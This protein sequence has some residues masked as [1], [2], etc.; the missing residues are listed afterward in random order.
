[1]IRMTG[2]ISGLDTDTIVAGLMSAQSMKKTKLENKITKN[3][4]TTE[5]WKTLNSK[6]YSLYT[7]TLS[8]A[9]TQGSYYSKSVSSSDSTKVTVTGTSSAIDGSHSLE[10]NKLAS[11]QYVTGAKIADLTTSTDEDGNVTE[12]TNPVTGTTLLTSL[13][14]NVS[15]SAA[16]SINITVGDGDTSSYKITSTSTVSD[17]VSAMKSAGISANYDTTQKR[18]FLSA[19]ESGKDSAFSVNATSSG[20]LSETGDLSLLGLANVSYSENTD[21]SLSY[22]TST[23]NDNTSV[24]SGMSLVGASDSEIVYN[25]ATL[26]GNTNS[27]TANGLTFNLLGTTDKA[28]TLSVTNDSSSVYDMVKG[29]ITEYDDVLKQ[30]NTYYNADSASDYEPLTDAQ[31]ES[32]SDDEITQWNDKIKGALLRRDSTL[33][34]VISTMTSTMQQSVT[35]NGQSYSLSSFGISSTDYTENGLLHIDG[36]SDDTQSSGNTDKLLAAIKSDPDAVMNTISTIAGSLYSGFTKEMGT[37]SLSSALTFYNDKEYSSQLSDYEDDLDDLEDKLSDM[38]DSYYE[39]FSNMET[40]L[41]KLNSQSSA[42]SSML[43]T[44]SS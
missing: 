10:I 5:V 25:G 12:E 36:N 29:F 21:G 2:L 17:L 15:D 11:A 4:W 9:K 3:K 43:G 37:S 7:G 26:T 8:K 39:Q 18:F 44:S 38:E 40:A 30:L 27:I 19:A 6:L 14:F 13:G 33:S 35:Y 32:M 31:K 22:T 34:N 16:T 24:P 23:G 28:L 1:M 20:D 41:A 42:L